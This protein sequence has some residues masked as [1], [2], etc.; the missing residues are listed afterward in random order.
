MDRAVN[1][2]RDS[3]SFRVYVLRKGALMKK[4]TSN[5]ERT[6]LALRK[7]TLR[8]LDSADLQKAAGGVRIWK[9]LGFAD[10]TTPIYGWSEI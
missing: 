9:P 7:E 6:P 3:G 5:Q 1:G 8:H 4:Q 2:I 10:D